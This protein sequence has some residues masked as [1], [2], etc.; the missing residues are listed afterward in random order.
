MGHAAALLHFQLRCET[1]Q[2]LQLFDGNR[3]QIQ[4]IFPE[5][6]PGG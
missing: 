4:E 3:E 5:A 6:S 1:Q 2:S